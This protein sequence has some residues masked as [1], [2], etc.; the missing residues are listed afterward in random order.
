MELPKKIE[1]FI[2]STYQTKAVKNVELT[3]EPDE[4][5]YPVDPKYNKTFVRIKS[6]MLTQRPP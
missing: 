3:T 4:Y 5:N 2:P 6:D 1:H